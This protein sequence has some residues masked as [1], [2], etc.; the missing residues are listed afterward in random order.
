LLFE[1]S[2]ATEELQVG[3]LFVGK[4]LKSP[5]L[6]FGATQHCGDQQKVVAFFNRGF[7]TANDPHVV[8]VPHAAGRVEDEAMPF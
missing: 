3:H 4:I 8:L 7:S 6:Y 1:C 5:V 2:S